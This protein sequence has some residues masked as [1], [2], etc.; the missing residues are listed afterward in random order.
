M[1]NYYLILHYFS[2]NNYGIYLINYLA[3]I[4]L[5]NSSMARRKQL[6][7]LA[8]RDDIVQDLPIV[9]EFVQIELADD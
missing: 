2:I 3:R 1:R 7:S 9:L 6:M 4:A 8:R 5:A